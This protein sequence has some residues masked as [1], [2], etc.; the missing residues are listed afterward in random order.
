MSWLDFFVCTLAASAIV[1]VWFNGSIFAG[2]RAL[3]QAVS[4]DPQEPATTDDLDE[5]LDDEQQELP[6]AMRVVGQ[7]MP[8]LLADMLLCVFCFSHHTPWVVIL[9]CFCTSYSCED[10]AWAF[11][12]KLPAYSLAMTRLGNLVNSYAP[13]AANYY[14]E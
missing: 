10:P 13:T 12:L 2:W 8:V 6:F 5:T 3:V 7:L 9:T 4:D 14:R 11:A 1:D